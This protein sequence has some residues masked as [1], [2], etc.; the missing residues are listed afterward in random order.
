M[1]VPICTLTPSTKQIRG[2][3]SQ[4]SP[5]KPSQRNRDRCIARDFLQGQAQG[6]RK[7]AK[8]RDLPSA[9]WTPRRAGSIQSDSTG[10]RTRST[11]ASFARFLYILPSATAATTASRHSQGRQTLHW[12]SPALMGSAI[13]PARSKHHQGPLP[14]RHGGHPLCTRH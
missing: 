10:P 3:I 11:G 5:E 4:G 13:V 8:S 2:C 7:A 6:I 12:L 9:S 14:P 1:W